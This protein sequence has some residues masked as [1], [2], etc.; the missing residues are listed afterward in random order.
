[1]ALTD[2]RLRICAFPQGWDGA[3]IAIRVLV[4][5]FGNPLQP[6]DLGLKAF[7]QAQLVLS[8]HLISNLDQ[9][10][11]PADVTERVVLDVTTP[12]NIEQV[13]TELADQF[14]VDPM[15]P[16]AYVPPA[17]TRFLKMLMPSYLEAS[18]FASP[19]TEFAV[20]DDRYVCA[21]VDGERPAQ[22]PPK[23][24]TPPKWDAVL[25]MAIRQP[26][27]AKQ[28]GLLYVTSVTPSD[29]SFYE[30]G[31]WLYVTLDTTSDYFVAAAAPDF[32][33][34]Y[35]A[36][37]P[38][39]MAAV[40]ASVFA[41]V[42]FPVTPVPPTGSFD[43]M[44]HEADV[45]S[46]GFARLVHT[47]Q[48][49][50]ADYLNLSRQDDRRLRPYEEV[51]L[52]LGWDDEQ[53]VIWLNRQ[54]TDDPRNGSPIARD[55]PLGVRGFRVDV[56]EAEG[57]GSW[58]SL[59]R[60][61][62]PI[63][64]G[65]LFLGIFD[66]EMA[67]E[68]A[69]SQLQG[70][71]D[72]EYWL[73]PYF[74]Q[75]TGSSLIAA[76]ATAFK[77]ANTTMGPRVLNP[78]GERSVPLRYGQLYQFR[79]R[80]TDLTGGGPGPE[81]KNEP[82][83]G[84]A[85]CR[86]RRFVPP[87]LPQ[88]EEPVENADGTLTL[89]IGRPML[90]YPSLLYT[91]LAGAEARLLADVTTAAAEGRLAGFPDPDVTRIRIDV[92]V[93]SLEFDPENYPGPEPR[94]RLYSTFREFDDDPEQLLELT[95]EFEDANDLAVFPAPAATGPIKLPTARTVELTFTPVARR[96]PSMLPTL[97][98]PATTEIIDSAA[99]DKDD[100]KLVYFGKQAARIGKRHIVTQRRESSSENAL[101]QEVPGVPFQSIFLQPSPIQ[102]AHLNDKNAAAGT[103]DQAPES[104]IQRLA[105]Q[106]RLQNRDLTLSGQAG[107]RV[108]FGASAAVRHI[109]S[110]DHSTITFAN[111]TEITAQW[112]IAIPLRL[113]RDWTWDALTD[114]G[115]QV[116]RSIN[117]S[118]SELVGLLSPRK[119]LSATVVR[120][121]VALDR[122][123]ID[124][125][126]FD[127]V[128]PKPAPGE[129]PS[130]IEITYTVMPQFRQAPEPPAPKW[131]NTVRLPMAA[132]P[133]QVP[134]IVS[135]GIA[136]SPY[137]RD[138]KYSQTEPRR[139][140][141]WI[142]FAD[143]VANPRDAYFA[144]V[145]M[146]SPDPMLIRGEPAQPPGPLEPPLNIDPEHIRS[147]IPDQPEESSGLEAMQ[148]LIPAEG[149]GPI[150]HF[151]LPLPPV[152]SEASPELF[153]FFVYEFR[154]GHAEGWSTAQARFGL[155]QRVTG[156]QHPVPVI[157]CSVARTAEYVRV[158]APYATPVA[159]GQILRA[160]PP[161]SDLWVL[162]YVQVRLADASDWRNILIGRTRLTFSELAFRGRSGSE[163]HGFGY[164]DQEEI[165]AWLEALGLPQNSPLSVVAVELLPEPDSPFMDPLGKDLG[166]VRVLRTSPLTPVPAICLD[167]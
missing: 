164:Y 90:G 88:I 149:D 69:P 152:L 98:D 103:R 2:T 128:D 45:Y 83:S 35:A 116:F 157:T 5:P 81:A 47:F 76:D 156:V 74:T 70:K 137:E 31:G 71:R 119:T 61:R 145:T 19:R 108:V 46:D 41:P 105:R 101:F 7:A 139:R 153:G 122:A 130:E 159:N 109:L 106:L 144:R 25:A 100:P 138:E 87:G 15:A 140:M 28:L 107:R 167:V 133:T 64:I 36:Y 56:R 126:F 110:P 14:N 96:D 132:I 54:I 18:G 86:F 94:Q 79:V 9:L 123:T 52:K 134:R 154:V 51:G 43:D 113:A 150:R 62:G 114:E 92:T 8:A 16:P 1:M 38:P 59:V 13:Y 91:P 63:Q 111:E 118:A 95:V 10:P 146:H 72:G 29:A 158:S 78:V 141:L 37:I 57:A 42:L 3:K 33:K 27:L 53:I 26:V 6:L 143:P 136:L 148:R 22:R 121:G 147:I 17:K 102:D 60:M 112:L 75:W 97:A 131:T 99:L 67:I 44:L 93:A 32:L 160:E 23:P 49:D 80:L 4:A 20:T 58:A 24:P 161:T 155:P 73:P 82:P 21:L 34:L 115:L 84:M 11:R 12:L 163:P 55:T 127:A 85:T 151:L 39:L 129:F 65:A 30:N 117:G 165:E 50:R 162:L 89:S 48:P 40:P 104:A 77:V 120:R 135:A 125:F 68:L 124:L 66:G 142:E 166:Q